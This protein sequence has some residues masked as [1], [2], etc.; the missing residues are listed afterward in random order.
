M[1][2]ASDEWP[3][4]WAVP[5][6]GVIVP[7]IA[8]VGSKSPSTLSPVTTSMNFVFL[9]MF[10]EFHFSLYHEAHDGTGYHVVSVIRLP[11]SL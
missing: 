11:V 8:R 10:F 5:A 7:L 1:N 3:V 6:A 9:P 2:G 4:T